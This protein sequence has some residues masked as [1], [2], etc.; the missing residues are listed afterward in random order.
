M[1]GRRDQFSQFL[2]PFSDVMQLFESTP[3]KAAEFERMINELPKSWV[4]CN[5][6]VSKDSPHLL[7]ARMRAGCAP[8]VARIPL[9]KLSGTQD[10]DDWPDFSDDEDE[11]DKSDA[12]DA[13]IE[14]DDAHMEEVK[15]SDQESESGE[16]GEE[17][18]HN[19]EEE[20]EICVEDSLH[21]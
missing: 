20:E 12:D 21:I 10:D 8:V 19:D 7:V 4:I 18:Q 1:E 2:S 16:S 15:G 9:K 11:C 5:I 17:E 14:K 3:H 6:C 13:S